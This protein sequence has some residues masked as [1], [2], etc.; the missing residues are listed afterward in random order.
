VPL[1]FIT[2]L[3]NSSLNYS[4]EKEDQSSTKETDKRATVIKVLDTI[5]EETIAKCVHLLEKLSL[6]ATA[7]ADA[8]E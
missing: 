4:D 5:T 3:L 1:H 6:P 7:Q 8:S 2:I